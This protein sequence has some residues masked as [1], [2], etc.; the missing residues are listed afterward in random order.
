[1]L[2]LNQINLAQGAI[3]QNRAVDLTKNYIMKSRQPILI[4]SELQAL[5]TEPKQETVQDDNDAIPD[6]V[7]DLSQSARKK[8]LE[9]GDFE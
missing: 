8:I 3:A 1:M 7:K 2:K 6:F 5:L 4:E 9:A